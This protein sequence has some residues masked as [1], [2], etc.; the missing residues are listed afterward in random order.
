VGF[1]EPCI[2]TRANKVPV[3]PQ[4]I[5]EIKHD[6]YRLIVCRRGV[7]VRLFTRRGYDWSDRYPLVVAAAAALG[8]D[9]TIDGEVVVCDGVAD[10]D[11]LH[12]REDDGR[13]FL[14]AF[15]LL[16]LDGDQAARAR[17]RAAPVPAASAGWH[18]VYRPPGRRWRGDIRPCLSTGTSGQ[19]HALS[20]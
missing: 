15:D 4:W 2:P 18:S 11:R 14:W 9:A 6:G 12:G 10:F 1:I 7:R 3:G 19:R 8:A 17:G 16:E 13:A 5:H 20:A